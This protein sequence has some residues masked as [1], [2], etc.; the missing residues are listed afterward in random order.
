ELGAV[1]NAGN[2]LETGHF[3]DVK[4][5]TGPADEHD[6]QQLT[7]PD[8]TGGLKTLFDGPLASLLPGGTLPA[9]PDAPH[10]NQRGLTG[11]GD[12][13][14]G[15]MA[16]RH[17]V[18]QLDH[19]DAKT[20][21]AALA[22]AEKLHYSGVVSAHSWDSPPESGR[23]YK[24]GGFVTPIAG[25]SPAA[26]VDEWRADKKLRAKSNPYRFGFGYGSDM[27]GLA[28]QAQPTSTHP[29]AYPFTSLSGG[30]TFSRERWGQRVFDLNDDGLANYGLY[31]DWLQELQKLGGPQV[32]KDMLAGAESYLEMW[33]RADGIRGPNCRARHAVFRA[34]SIGAFRLGDGYEA[35]LRRA[36][37]PADR[38][39]TGYRW[40]VKRSKK[41]LRVAFTPAGKV[42][43]I[44]TTASDHSSG[45][46]HPGAN[47]TVLRG[48]AKKAGGGLW[49][50][51]KRVGGRRMAFG[52]RG[53]RVR[54]VALAGRA[55]GR[56]ART[57]RAYLRRAGV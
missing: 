3:W 30:V 31:P 34:A 22:L 40:C 50:G 46:V 32:G 48:R 56:N 23:I 25:S 27:N 47:A 14:I 18:L 36:G 44:A 26:F 33:E 55:A 41:A 9:Y 15:Q 43:M 8:P 53:G 21:D 17:D 42:G 39:A 24:L 45:K 13:L 51:P 35:V 7:A 38:T 2:H 49:L 37:Q 19:M 6:Q 5:C 1:I 52:V 4:T 16:K 20:A 57:V 11:L 29:I 54:F 28:E 12:Y 10:C